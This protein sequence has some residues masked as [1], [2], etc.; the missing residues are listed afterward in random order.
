LIEPSA[1]DGFIVHCF[2][3][4]DDPLQNKDEIRRRLGLE[5][6]FRRTSHKPRPVPK[7]RG[8]DRGLLNFA[9]RIWRE[10]RP[11]AGTLGELYLRHH[12]KLEWSS[13]LDASVRFHPSLKLDGVPRPTVVGLFR[14]FATG[15]PRG[16]HRIFLAEDGDKIDRGMLGPSAG[17]AV[18]LDGLEDV[19]SGLTIAEGI[20]TAMAARQMGL[21]PSWALGTAS[22]IGSFPV[23]PGIEFITLC[24]ETGPA[25]FE[26]TESCKRRWLD[27]GREGLIVTP[28]T[29]SDLNDVVKAAAK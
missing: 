15:A 3:P 17:A 12:R 14:D 24:R 26:T 21:R 8:E 20:E 9:T 7:P 1:P 19:E 29:G 6:S 13:D 25:S 28:R 23:L 10:T 22:K 11:I 16:I 5:R 4:G 27:A 18:M 2:A